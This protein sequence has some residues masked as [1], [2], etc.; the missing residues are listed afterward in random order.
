MPHLATSSS[1]CLV[2]SSVLKLIG[3][4]RAGK[5]R[6]QVPWLGYLTILMQEIKYVVFAV[7]G[8]MVLRSILA[9]DPRDQQQG[10]QRMPS[11]K[12]EWAWF[13]LMPWS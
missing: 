11:S 2:V 7:I 12:R 8:L 9:A 10:E 1:T 4:E 13:L 3:H 6:G 5:V